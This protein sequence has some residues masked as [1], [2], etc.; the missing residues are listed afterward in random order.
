MLIGNIYVAVKFAKLNW[1]VSLSAKPEHYDKLRVL[2]VAIMLL[3]FFQIQILV[4]DTS[5]L[6]I[7]KG[8]NIHIHQ[9]WLGCS[10]G[11]IVMFS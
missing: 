6:S 5:H 9:T 3:S 4:E 1:G 11:L 8:L 7:R 2:L 10:L